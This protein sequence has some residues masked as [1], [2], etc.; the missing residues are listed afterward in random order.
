MVLLFSVLRVMLMFVVRTRRRGHMSVAIPQRR[1]RSAEGEAHE[2]EGEQQG[3][4]NQDG[5][6]DVQLGGDDVLLA[7]ELADARAGGVAGAPARAAERVRDALAREG[8]GA[9]DDARSAGNVGQDRR[10][11]VKRRGEVGVGRGRVVR[12]VRANGQEVGAA[13]HGRDGERG[14]VYGFEREGEGDEVEDGWEDQG[15]DGEEA[16]GKGPARRKG[17]SR[18]WMA[19]VVMSGHDGCCCY[20]LPGRDDVR[21]KASSW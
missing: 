12:W 2:D 10:A 1:P 11:G 18:G 9:R 3:D 20:F 21:T 16:E 8:E 14:L 5:A 4:A 6:R 15:Q 13:E 7:E 17:G 19:V